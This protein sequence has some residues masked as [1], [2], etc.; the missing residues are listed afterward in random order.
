MHRV[1]T[2]NWRRCAWS[3]IISSRRCALSDVK[4]CH[5]ENR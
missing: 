4:A 5:K 2:I 3:D 1:T